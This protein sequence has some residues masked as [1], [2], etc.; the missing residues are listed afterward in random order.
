M[1]D[2]RPATTADLDAIVALHHATTPPAPSAAA[3]PADPARPQA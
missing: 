2:V 1:T 3:H